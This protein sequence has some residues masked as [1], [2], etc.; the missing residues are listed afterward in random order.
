MPESKANNVLAMV[1]CICCGVSLQVHPLFPPVVNANGVEVDLCLHG[2]DPM[3]SVAMC[4]VCYCFLFSSVLSTKHIFKTL[5]VTLP[6]LLL[7]FELTYFQWHIC[8]CSFHHP[9]L[10][11]GIT[12]LSLMNTQN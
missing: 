5:P 6:Y 9:S 1:G 11:M 2:G 7:W 10:L 8:F 4:F 3:S 12:L